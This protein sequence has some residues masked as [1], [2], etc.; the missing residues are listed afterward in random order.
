MGVEATPARDALGVNKPE[1][2]TAQFNFD[3]DLNDDFLG[4]DAGD[5]ENQLNN[6]PEPK[7]DFEIVAPEEDENA[8]EEDNDEND[9]NAPNEDELRKQLAEMDMDQET[10]DARAAEDMEETLEKERQREE[11][12]RQAR[13]EKRHEPIKRDLPRPSIINESI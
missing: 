1:G 12:E 2:V 5:L 3:D 13:M 11:A 7:N 10:I 8:M 4:G 9:E 6:L